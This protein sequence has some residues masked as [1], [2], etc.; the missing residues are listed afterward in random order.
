[1]PQQNVE[2][3]RGLYAAF[4]K[5]D[6][7]GV[8]GAMAPDIEWREAEGSIFAGGNPYIGANAILN[9]VL[10]KLATEWEKYA[11]TPAHF[12]DAGDN[13]IVTGRYTGKYHAT[14]KSLDAQF[15]HF[16]NL[17]DGK[18]A[19]FQQYTDTLQAAKVVANT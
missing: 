7:P 1:M 13:V 15:A 14:G 17:K 10:I 3:M 11:V 9:G 5:G 18:I 8:M 6:V 2:L 12:H 16:W 19:S 4:A